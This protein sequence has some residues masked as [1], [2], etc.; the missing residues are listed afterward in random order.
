MPPRRFTPYP[1]GPAH[2][3]GP[4]RHAPSHVGQS[5]R[6][7]LPHDPTRM[8]HIPLPRNGPC[9]GTRWPPRLYVSKE[10]MESLP[11]KHPST[12][13]IVDVL[14]QHPAGAGVFHRRA[15]STGGGRR[16][17]SYHAYGKPLASPAHR[18][19]P[20]GS[21]S[22]SSYARATQRESPAQVGRVYPKP[23]RCSPFGDE[24]GVRFPWAASS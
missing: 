5:L 18:Q 19:L 10:R 14:W 6:A 21:T 2:G 20:R 1:P 9:S 11:G 17:G 24:N 16:T 15:R 13:A 12:L 8:S 23:P 7:P 4:T 3:P 22:P